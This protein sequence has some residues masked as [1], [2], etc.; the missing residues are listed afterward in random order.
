MQ[1]GEAS[2]PQCEDCL[3][4]NVWAPPTTVP[5]PVL[6]WIHGGGFTGGRSFDP[7]TDGTRFARDGVVCVTIAYRLG[8]FGFLDLGGELG[9][10]Y[11]GSANNALRDVMAALVWVRDHIA[12][13]GG[14][15]QRVTI[16]GESAG[17]KIADLLMGVPEA[18]PLFQQVI[19][20]SGGA[21]RI[22]T[23]ERSRAVAK[24]FCGQWVTDAGQRCPQ[25]LSAPARQI[26]EAQ[27]AFLRTWPMHFP[28]RAEID[29]GLIPELPINRIRAGS[30]RGKRLLIGTNRDESALFLG[31]HPQT[32]PGAKDLGNMGVAEF[33]AVEQRYPAVYPAMTDEQRRIRSATA[34]EYWIPSLRVAD[35]HVHAGG[36]AFVYLL[37]EAAPAGRWKGYAFHSYDLRFVWEHFGEGGPTAGEQQL[38]DRMHAAWVA[39]IQGEPPEAPGLPAWPAYNPKT[40]PTMMLDEESHVEGAPQAAE[41]ALWNGLLPE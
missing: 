14:D 11:A 10:G 35:A 28:L 3:Y 38:A 4:L 22:F 39:F 30:T 17:A 9:P 20:E 1:P 26:L 29:G 8:V 24:G 13:F 40:R 31:P 41:F 27:E 15:R 5:L 2:I 18:D 21:E 34:E 12:A 37:D 19:S 23:Q 32:D 25:L 36:E 7:L 16:G 6:V 33:R